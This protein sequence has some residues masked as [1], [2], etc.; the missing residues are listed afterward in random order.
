MNLL[1]IAQAEIQRLEAKVEA[2]ESDIRQLRRDQGLDEA[3]RIAGVLARRFVLSAQEAW[4]LAALYATKD[5]RTKGWMTDHMPGYTDKNVRVPNHVSVIVCRIRK[6]IG[7]A[8]VVT[9]WGRGYALSAD[10][11]ALVAEALE[12]A[13]GWVSAGRREFLLSGGRR[14]RAVEAVA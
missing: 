10:G 8:A 7:A 3:E 4:A 2:L 11:R 13:D 12:A 9:I 14:L 1:D 6:R 5:M